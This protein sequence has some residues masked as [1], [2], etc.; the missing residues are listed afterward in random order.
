MR[1]TSVMNFSFKTS[2]FS[3]PCIEIDSCSNWS[4]TRID[5]MIRSP[6]K[7]SETDSTRRSAQTIS[8]RGNRRLCIKGTS[9]NRTTHL[10]DVERGVRSFLP[11]QTIQTGIS[12]HVIT[13]RGNGREN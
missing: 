7:E 8:N 13:S 4:K 5:H 11:R 2:A 10:P 1:L 6:D 12:K 3:E 9:R